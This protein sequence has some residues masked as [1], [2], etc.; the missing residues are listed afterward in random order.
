MSVLTC[1]KGMALWCRF[2]SVDFELLEVKNIAALSFVKEDNNS[3]SL[4]LFDGSIPDGQSVY[5]Y[6]SLESLKKPLDDGL[7]YIN[8][9]DTILLAHPTENN[10][11]EIDTYFVDS[12]S[13][14]NLISKD[15]YTSEDEISNSKAFHR[16]LFIKWTKYRAS[17]KN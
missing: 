16:G 17:L 6:T 7:V 3:L 10:I 4:N 9:G 14:I 12:K 1:D 5:V 8:P 15:I 13:D 2:Y 11:C